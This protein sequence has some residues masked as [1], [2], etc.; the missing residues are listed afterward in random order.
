MSDRIVSA[1]G[2]PRPNRLLRGL[3]RRYLADG[4]EDDRY[5]WLAVPVA[6]DRLRDNPLV[7]LGAVWPTVLRDADAIG[8]I[9]TGEPPEVVSPREMKG[10]DLG[11]SLWR[12][13]AW[14]LVF[15]IR[16]QRP[17]DTVEV[18]VDGRDHVEDED[19]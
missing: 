18:T 16:E 15:P 2:V 5:R 11:A 4:A 14:W 1:E 17:S 9:P 7:V 13:G 12:P 8:S 3:D 19:G 10:R 6:G